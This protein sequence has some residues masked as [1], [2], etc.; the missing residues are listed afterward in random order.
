[1]STT[2]F[3]LAILVPIAL[4]ITAW[5]VWPLLR[6]TAAAPGDADDGSARADLN[7]AIVRDSRDM[8][9]APPF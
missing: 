4:A 1:M 6:R 2:A 9:N 3:L 8:L 7:A 5:V